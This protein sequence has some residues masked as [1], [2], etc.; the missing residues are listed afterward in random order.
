MPHLPAVSRSADR[1]GWRVGL[2]A[3]GLAASTTAVRA[4]DFAPTLHTQD[5][6]L[7]SACTA[8][9]Q[10]TWRADVYRTAGQ[11]AS[12]D[13][14]QLARALACATGRAARRA[15]A[16]HVQ[17]RVVSRVEPVQPEGPSLVDADSDQ[18]RDGYLK[19][20][21]WGARVSQREGDLVVQF[22]TNEFCWAGATLRFEGR[23]W[24]LAELNGGCD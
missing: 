21:A 23:R 22:S 5:G 8:A 14:W 19:G 6:D 16:P 7:V 9:G 17:G 11:R 13:A 3:L 24:V 18:L 20:G 15:I 12:E 1:Q 4:A 2:C 10:A